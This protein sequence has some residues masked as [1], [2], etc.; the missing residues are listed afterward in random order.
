[1]PSLDN[2]LASPEE[3]VVLLG[4]EALDHMLDAGHFNSSLNLEFGAR[5]LLTEWR[6][7]NGDGYEP[8]FKA[9]YDR[10]GLISRGTDA[11]ALRVREL[12]AQHF[13]EHVSAGF[14]DLAMEAMRQVRGN[15]FWEAGWRDVND[16]LHF[17]LR[18]DG[19]ADCVSLIALERNLRPRSADA[20]AAAS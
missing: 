3:D 7:Y 17:E 2:M 8:W 20:R 5:A 1:M 9:A 12:I 14:A 15:G 11:P 10:L 6:P 13:R 4:V 19:N 16:A 18:R